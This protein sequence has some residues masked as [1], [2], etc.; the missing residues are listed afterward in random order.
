MRCPKCN[1]W[2]DEWNC[3]HGSKMDKLEAEI[4]ERNQ[5]YGDLV[6][7]LEHSSN[8]WQAE[9]ERLRE[10]ASEGE[11]RA[12]SR[13]A[14]LEVGVERLETLVEEAYLEG[15]TDA[16]HYYGLTAAWNESLTKK[17]LQQSSDTAGG[18]DE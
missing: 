6:K 9:V 2:P 5:A 11:I 17:L 8:T 16:E 14:K 13:I 15:Y 12:K 4:A 18:E 1:A 3:W 10:A 7:Q